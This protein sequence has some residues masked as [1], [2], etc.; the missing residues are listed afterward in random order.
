MNHRRVATPINE[1][2]A[3]LAAC[4][5]LKDCIFQRLGNA[6]LRFVYARID[7]PHGRERGLL[8]G[9][10]RQ[11]QHIVVAA[12]RMRPA[13]QRRRRRAKHDRYLRGIGAIDGQIARGIAQAFLLLKRGVV[14]FVD[15]DQSELGHG[16]KHRQPRAEHNARLAFGGRSP[17]AVARAVA[18][19]AV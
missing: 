7:Q 4:E 15:N 9:A 11:R 8:M 1:Y 13:F 5:T 10:L 16:R 18:Q 14:F 19:R 2:E 12:L 17:R 3:L 6:V